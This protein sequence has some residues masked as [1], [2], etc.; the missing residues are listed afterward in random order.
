MGTL[1]CSAEGKPL[2]GLLK[3]SPDFD[4]R[5]RGYTPL[6]TSMSFYMIGRA[7]GE[8]LIGGSESCEVV[9]LLKLGL[10]SIRHTSYLGFFP[11]TLCFQLVTVTKSLLDGDACALGGGYHDNT[12]CLN[13]REGKPW[14]LRELGN[15]ICSSNNGA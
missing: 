11:A 1:W 8:E 13:F 4:G 9:Y 12:S 14:L 5:L 3:S 7:R 10:L 15:Q 6:C 2:D